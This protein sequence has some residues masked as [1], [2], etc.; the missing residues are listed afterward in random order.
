MGGA[1]KRCKKVGVIV[2]FSLCRRFTSLLLKRD[3]EVP[4]LA[5]RP[6]AFECRIASLLFTPMTMSHVGASREDQ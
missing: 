3:V 2:P 5:G 6:G 4:G 1:V